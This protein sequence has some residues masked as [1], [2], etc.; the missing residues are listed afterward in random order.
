MRALITGGT[1]LLGKSLLETRPNGWELH[2]TYCARPPSAEW[3]ADWHPLD[4]RDERAVRR[5]VSSL[6]PDVVIHTASVGSVDE[7]ERDPAGVRQVNVQGVERVGRACALAQARLVFVSSNAVFDGTRPPYGEDAA[8]RA[9][10]RY[11][12]L[13]IE[14]EAWVRGSGLPHAIVRPILMYGWPLP[15]GRENVMTRWLRQLE[16]GQPLA[17]ADD[18]YSMPL[19]AAN[20]AEAIWAVV[21][22]QRTGTYHLAGADRLSLFEFAKAVA[23]AFGH[24][25]RLVHPVPHASLPGLAPR[26]KDTAFITTRMARDLGVR[27]IGVDEGLAG[28]A[29]TR[30][31]A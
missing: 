2:L 15:G 27:P 4:V 26:P 18:L 23:R 29:R 14:A 31:A 19:L 3:P 30:V 5:L 9:V 10:N 1:G 16:A 11:G 28:L 20:G 7:A 6:R 8:V 13:K 21:A 25:E 12:A 24:P 22:Q 17:V